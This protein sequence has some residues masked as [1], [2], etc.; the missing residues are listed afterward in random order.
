MHDRRKTVWLL[1]V[2]ASVGLLAAACS[3][4]KPHAASGS[5]TSTTTA[6]TSATPTTVVV[7]KGGTLNYGADQEP[8]GFNANTSKDSGIANVNV[9]A[10][11]WPSAFQLYP[12]LTVHY[13]KALLTSDPQVIN[14]D[15]QT[16]IFHINPKANWSDGVPINADDFIYFWNMQKDPAHTNDSCSDGCA[17]NGKPIN[18]STDGTGYRN[19]NTIA[20]SDNGKTV[21]VTFKKG[22]PYA[23]WRS[24]F[25][26]M[27][28]AHIA[29]KVGWNDGFDHFDP[30]VVISGGP[31]EI[32]SYH[33]GS[34]LTLVPNPGYW[35][36]PANLDQ[37]V[38]HF[39]PNSNAQIPA[40][41]NGEVDMLY[42]QPQLDEVNQVKELP[43]I[44]SQI[45][46]GLEFEHVDFNEK[47]AFLSD[48]VVRKAI[49]LAIDRK[50]LVQATVG[51]FSSR[52]QVLN[53]RMYVNTQPEYTDNSGGLY[54]KAQP[55]LA[56]Q[57]LLNDGFTLGTDNYLHKGGKTLSLRISS[58][59]G[60]DLRVQEEEII[61]AQLK[62]AGIELTIVNYQSGD[63][64]GTELPNGNFDIALFSWVTSPFPTVSNSVYTTNGGLNWDYISDPSLDAKLVAAAATT[65]PTTEVA[66][67]NAADRI[68]WQ[69]MVSLPLFQKPTFI[70]VR[71][72]FGNIGDNT[73]SEGPFWNA[74]TWGLKV[75][76]Q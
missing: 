59:S 65:D 55:A 40:L 2:A 24:L 67:Y 1:A 5:G 16:V 7:R 73:T 10:R 39:I 71:N 76:A 53:N 22:Q 8:T 47:N 14:Q 21:T 75:G 19:I 57:D 20:G 12:D 30:K 38:F 49:A 9:M 45:D 56:K 52:A 35:A 54:S 32:S 62:A 34:D 66:D 61:Q 42:P 4:S 44:N 28:P 69:Q 17:Q 31:F 15:P 43:G 48:E 33:P 11:V 13:D 60:I 64:F 72:T 37:I 18:D 58:T 29:V 70:A 27:P 3:S 63:F 68:C 74:E 46:F 51:Q 41:E 23:D 36:T 26:L 25:E 6:P 50:V